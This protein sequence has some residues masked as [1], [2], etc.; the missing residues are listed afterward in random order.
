MV[1]KT[2]RQSSRKATD[3]H[4]VYGRTGRTY[5]ITPN[6][7]EKATKKRTW[8]QRLIDKVKTLIGKAS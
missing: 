2:M 7:W 8:W 4:R 5:K 3:I 6:R 1:T